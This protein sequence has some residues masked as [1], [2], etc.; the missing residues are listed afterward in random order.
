MNENDQNTVVLDLYLGP[1]DRLNIHT[2]AET[3]S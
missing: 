2:H 3:P 1:V